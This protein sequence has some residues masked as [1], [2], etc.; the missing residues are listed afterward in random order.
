M[1][2]KHVRARTCFGAVTPSSGS[3]VK[4]AILTTAPPDD[5]VTAPKYV[6]DFFNVNFNVNLKIVFKTIHLYTSW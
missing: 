6:R 2:P 4:I 3:A 5:G 1:R